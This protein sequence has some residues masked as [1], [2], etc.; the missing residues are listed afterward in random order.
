MLVVAVRLVSENLYSNIL[1]PGL[2]SNNNRGFVSTFM[3]TLQFWVTIHVGKVII[4]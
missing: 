2:F 3:L 1:T 4:L